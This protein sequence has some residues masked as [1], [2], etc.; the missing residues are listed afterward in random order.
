MSRRRSCGRCRSTLHEG[1]VDQR[2]ETVPL[3]R[4]SDFRPLPALPHQRRDPARR[5][6]D[7]RRAEPAAPGRLRGAYR[8]RRGPFRRAGE[9]RQRATDACR[10]RSSWSTR[11]TTCCSSTCTPSTAFRA[12]S[13]GDGEARRRSTNWATGAW[14]KLKNAHQ[15]GRQGHL[16]RTDRPLRQSARPRRASP[17]RHDSL[18][19]ARAGSL[20]PLGGHARPADGHGGRQGGHGVATSRWTG[21]CAATWASERP[22]WR[23]A[24][25]SR[26]PCDGKQVAVLVPTTILALQHYRSFTERLRDFPGEGGVPQPHQIHEGG[27]PDPSRIWPRGGSTS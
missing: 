23:S 9:D 5:A 24:R 12:T 6:D 11:T 26:P 15:E 4:P 22:R 8:P 27:Q 3:H 25:R 10:R 20:V 1:F 17:S 2:P 7:R 18:F 21:W 14:Q 19:A 16:A 13:A